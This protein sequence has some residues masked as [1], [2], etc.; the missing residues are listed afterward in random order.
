LVICVFKRSR[1]CMDVFFF[2]CLLDG[3]LCPPLRCSYPFFTSFCSFRGGLFFFFFNSGLRPYPLSSPSEVS[4]ASA[5]S[6]SL[7]CLFLSR[8]ANALS[9]IS[10]GLEKVI[11]E[12]RSDSYLFEPIAG[13]WPHFYALSQRGTMGAPFFAS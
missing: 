13:D 7:L 3:W 5:C 12:P 4:M 9:V 2:D 10:L 8:R 6:W 1:F 11:C